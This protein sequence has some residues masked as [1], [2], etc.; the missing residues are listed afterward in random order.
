MLSIEKEAELKKR[1]KLAGV[2]ATQKRMEIFHTLVLANRA[3]SPYE[4]AHFCEND[5]SLSIPVVSIYR[6]LDLLVSVN[7]VHKL[8]L[9]NKYIACA[10]LECQSHH[11]HSQFLICNVC[12]KVTEIHIPHTI[13]SELSEH[14]SK[15]GFQLK[16]PQYEFQGICQACSS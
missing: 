12:Q 3:L 11:P 16:S 4:L 1:F 6:T 8:D 2:K 10:H 14:I 9:V 5:F 15:H 7:L 13:T